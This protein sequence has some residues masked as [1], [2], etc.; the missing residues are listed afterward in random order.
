MNNN[1]RNSA[2]NRTINNQNNNDISP[3]S[4]KNKFQN[5][6][7]ALDFLKKTNEYIRNINVIKR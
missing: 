4:R 1:E 7:S 2:K 6:P 3:N 5:S